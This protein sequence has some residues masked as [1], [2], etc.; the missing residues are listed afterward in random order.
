MYF[1][2]IPVFKIKCIY[3]LTFSLI[4]CVSCS[5]EEREKQT[6]EPDATSE[7]HAPNTSMSAEVVRPHLLLDRLEFAEWKGKC[8][9]PP[10]LELSINKIDALCQK[11]EN[12]KNQLRP[13][14]LI[15]RGSDSPIGCCNGCQDHLQGD[16]FFLLDDSLLEGFTSLYSTDYSSF[17]NLCPIDWVEEDDLSLTPYTFYFDLE[18]HLRLVECSQGD[19]DGISS[20]QNS[21]YFQKG[22]V[23]PFFIHSTSYFWP[24]NGDMTSNAS[25]IYVDNDLDENSHPVL[26]HCI[27]EYSVQSEDSTKNIAKSE[28]MSIDDIMAELKNFQKQHLIALSKA[29]KVQKDVDMNKRKEERLFIGDDKFAEILSDRGFEVVDHKIHHDEE[30]CEWDYSAVLRNCSEENII[31]LMVEMIYVPDSNFTDQKVIFALDSAKNRGVKNYFRQYHDSGSLR[32]EF[33]EIDNSLTHL[34]PMFI[35]EA[36]YYD[37]F[38]QKICDNT[39]H[40]KDLGACQ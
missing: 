6:T 24:Y 28:P 30:A 21:W 34:A 11:I 20:N 18:G 10:D 13:Y 38:F 17:E 19:I 40:L 3:T 37:V 16:D 33:S 7:K 22:E 29:T 4:F 12:N 27:Q 9:N 39:W 31:K 1:K 25:R 35:Y 23:Y 32:A 14:S 5:N 15:Y 26:I 2:Q 8:L 36:Q